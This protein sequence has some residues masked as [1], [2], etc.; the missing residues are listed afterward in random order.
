M[1]VLVTGA[2]GFIGQ[3][4]VP[5]LLHN[6]YTVTCLIRDR[7]KA[8]ALDYRDSVGFVY[9]DVTKPESLHF[10]ID[11]DYVIHLA[12][13]GHVSAA[14]EEAYRQFKEINEGGTDNLI[15]ALA[16]NK[17]LKRFIHFSSTAAMGPIGVPV[18]NE[19]MEN[20]PQTPYQKS[21][22]RSERVSLDAFAENSFPCVIIRPCMVYGPGGEGEFLKFCRLMKKGLFP[23]VGRGK[24]LTP[25]VYVDDVVEATLL[26][27]NK[28]TIG[29]VYIIASADS[30]PMD[31]IRNHVVDCIGVNPPYVYVPL[32]AAIL[33]SK[34]LEVFCRV[35]KKTPIVTST[36]IRS[37]ST[38]RTFDI[39]K[40]KSELGYDPKTPLLDG[41]KATIQWYRQEN[42]L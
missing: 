27:L 14:S 7:E 19:D 20:N 38:N 10:D 31:M 26:A 40:A 37:S 3:H 36:N 12:A 24:N 34:M 32:W 23:K 5:K 9:G 29:N 17:S 42:L 2:T 11:F 1:N 28:S 16:V 25:M 15:K 18:L 30:Y 21:K 8:E 33:Y 35:V 39:T 22:D 13:M 6:G 4:L 41:I